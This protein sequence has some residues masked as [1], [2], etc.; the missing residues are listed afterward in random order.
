MWYAYTMHYYS[1][2]KGNKRTD[3]HPNMEEPQKHYLSER[4]QTLKTARCM[5]LL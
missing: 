3:P 1:T 4:S 5:T 2:M